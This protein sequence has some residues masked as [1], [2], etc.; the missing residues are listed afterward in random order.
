LQPRKVSI[1]RA[2]EERL[3][4]ENRRILSEWR[5]VVLLHRASREIPESER[6]WERT[7]RS[8]EEIRPILARLCQSGELNSLEQFPTLYIVTAPYARSQAVDEE[9]ILMELHPYAALSHASALAFHQMTEQL[10]KE[11][12]ASI[13]SDGASS[14]L[15]IGTRES[16]WAGAALVRSHIPDAILDRP[17]HWHRLVSQ[18]IFGTAEYDNRGYPVRVTTPERTLL[19]GLVHPEWCG[20]F[21]NVLKSW[22]AYRDLADVETIV[23]YVDQYGMAILRQRAGFLLEQLHL[24]HPALERWTTLAR[25]G[26]SSKLNGG[27]PFASS[28]SGRWQ[29]SINAPLGPLH[30]EQS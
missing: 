20:G 5:A 13:P 29:L 4:A 25:R 22:A 27:A 10:P 1:S 19:D 23:Q 14:L 26:G 21:S 11:I 15:P 3:A 9:E 6:R 30:E 17:V 24:S 16:D 18:R 7:P 12:H 8:L 2:L 28:Y